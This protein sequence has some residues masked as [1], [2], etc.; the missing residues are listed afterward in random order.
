LK[1]CPIIAWDCQKNLK[2]FTFIKFINLLYFDLIFYNTKK[3]I[4]FID[5]VRVDKEQYS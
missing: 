1:L 2:T 3:T 5:E 4:V